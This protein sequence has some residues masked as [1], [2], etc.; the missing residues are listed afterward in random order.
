MAMA[1]ADWAEL[2]RTLL[3]PDNETLLCT[4]DPSDP[5]QSLA[6]AM[7]KE[8][9]RVL[10]ERGPSAPRKKPAIDPVRHRGIPDAFIGAFEEDAPGES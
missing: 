8:L 2:A 10:A 6:C 4:P 9:L 3:D 7:R 5:V 1:D